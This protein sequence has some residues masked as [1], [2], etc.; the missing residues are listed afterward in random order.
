MMILSVKVTVIEEKLA[1]SRST[2]EVG[3]D[4]DTRR[5]VLGATW[6]ACASRVQG[7]AL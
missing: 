7:A 2:R 1:A 5:G 6:I 4:D 3:G